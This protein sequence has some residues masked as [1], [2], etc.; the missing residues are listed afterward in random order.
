[1]H[2]SGHQQIK[3]Q[4]CQGRAWSRASGGGD[5]LILIWIKFEPRR[6]VYVMQEEAQGFRHVIGSI[7]AGFLQIRGKLGDVEFSRV[8]KSLELRLGQRRLD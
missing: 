1:M 4:V 2:D 3:A 6:A 8:Q 5:S 7:L